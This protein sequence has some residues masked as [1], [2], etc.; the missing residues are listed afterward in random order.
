MKGNYRK[1]KALSGLYEFDQSIDIFKKLKMKQEI[2]KT[3][4]YKKLSDEDY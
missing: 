1:A 2:I 3:E 4:H